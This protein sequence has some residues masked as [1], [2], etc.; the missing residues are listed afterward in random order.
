MLELTLYWKDGC[1]SMYHVFWVRQF[2]D[3]IEFEL[4]T[5]NVGNYSKNSFNGFKI[6]SYGGVKHVS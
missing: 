5:G 1:E 6:E 2:N 3:V 4:H